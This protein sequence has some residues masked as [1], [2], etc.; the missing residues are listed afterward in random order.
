MET[1]SQIFLPLGFPEEGPGS[2]DARCSFSKPLNMG[3]T[4]AFWDSGWIQHLAV[5]ALNYFKVFCVLFMAIVINGPK[6]FVLN[7]QIQPS[8]VETPL[9]PPFKNQRQVDPLNSRSAWTG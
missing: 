4:T 3:C 9:I 2:V 1:G 8:M 6:V 7:Q 5:E